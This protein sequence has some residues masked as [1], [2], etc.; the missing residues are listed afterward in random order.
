MTHYESLIVKV[1][2]GNADPSEIHVLEKWIAESEDNRLYYNQQVLLWDLL[3]KTKPASEGD[4]DHAWKNFVL[5]TEKAQKKNTYF[6]HKIAALFIILLVSSSLFFIFNNN[7][8]QLAQQNPS[9]KQIKINLPP[10]TKK[11]YI[12][13]DLSTTPKDGI[14]LTKKTEEEEDFFEFSNERVTIDSSVVKVSPKTTLNFL[15]HTPNQ[16]RISSL[17]GAGLFDIKPKDKDFV[18]ETDELRIKVQGTNFNIKTATEDYQFVE[19][20]VEEGFMEVSEKLNPDNKV[21]ISSKQKFIY[22]IEKHLFIET[23]VKTEVSSK[24]K[25]FIHKVFNTKN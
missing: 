15:D 14:K 6:I 9:K 3:G 5:K 1:I 22:D 13:Y 4:L 24:W 16:P 21:T 12:E 2:S 20:S 8:V 23:T 11:G 19:I 18:L 10:S 7:E 25:K 17:S